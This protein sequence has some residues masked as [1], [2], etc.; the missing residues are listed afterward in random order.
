MKITKKNYNSYSISELINLGISEAE[1]GNFSEAEKIYLQIIDLNENYLLAYF[2]LLIINES[3]F[4]E[5]ILKKIKYILKN[6]NLNTYEKSI[7]NFIISFYERKKKNFKKEIYY[8]DKA[9][10]YSFKSNENI[11]KQSN[12]YFKKIIK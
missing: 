10:S 7:A 8:L 5:K 11:N 4:D 12:Y 3:L 2:N 9:Y 6:S 1:K